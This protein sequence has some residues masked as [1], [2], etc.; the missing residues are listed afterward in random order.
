M[1]TSP[2]RVIN[3]ISPAEARSEIA[4]YLASENIRKIYPTKGVL[5]KLLELIDK[6]QIARQQ[7]FDL[8]LVATMLINGV[9]Q[10][11]TFNAKHFE[12]YQEIQVLLPE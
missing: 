9:T 6:Y 10:I 2:K 12:P 8:Q 5:P 7:I 1:I 11:Y 3:P 4:K